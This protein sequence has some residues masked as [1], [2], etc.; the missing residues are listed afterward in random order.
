LGGHAQF[1]TPSMMRLQSEGEAGETIQDAARVMSRYAAG[2]GIRIAESAIPYYGA[3][4]QLINEYAK[5]STVPVINMAD[6]HYHPCQGLAD[7]LG[8]SE[9]FGER[10]G[11][12]VFSN[13]KNKNLLLTWAHGGM[14]RTWS[15]VHETLLLA[16][17]FGM[18]ITIARPEG[19]DLDP[20]LYQTVSKNCETHNTRFTTTDD[21]VTSYDN[22]HVV[23][24]RNWMS[25]NAYQNN[26]FQKEAEI[27]H[28]MEKKEW[29]TTK[30]KMSR[31]DN[32]IFT[33][34]MPVDRGF[35]V[36][37]E[38]ADSERSIIYDVAENRLH[39]Q[40]AIMALTM[41]QRFLD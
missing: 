36:T 41:S 24:S 6:D 32:A 14:A 15:S 37:D 40:K 20:A 29:I 30:E 25:P 27:K 38:V 11:A 33:H 39:V 18:N 23:Y 16:S 4:D 5:W 12:P 2:I 35:E 1:I 26:L 31:T 34:C 8:W 10:E 7:I 28:A 19:Y 9:K 21:H 17:R 13:L 22:A 3:G